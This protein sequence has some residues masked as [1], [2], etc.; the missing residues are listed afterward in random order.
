M[1]SA[2]ARVADGALTLAALAGVA[3]TALVVAGWAL[4]FSLVLFSTG[5]MAPT[6]PTGSLALVREVPASEVG[7]GD[8]VTVDRPGRLPVTHRVVANVPTPTPGTAV[9]VLQ[10]DANARPDAEPYVVHEVR[11]VEASVPVL[12]HVVGALQHPAALAVVSLGAAALVTATLWPHAPPA[13]TGGP[14]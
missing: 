2:R 9:L 7:P 13:R 8:V 14:A 10:G 3:C 11:V 12:G 6:I 5:S 4:G 1:R